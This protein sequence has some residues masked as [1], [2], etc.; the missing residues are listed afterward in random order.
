MTGGTRR[1][2]ASPVRGAAQR[3]A[4]AGRT[5]H[6]ILAAGICDAALTQFSV[7]QTTPAIDRRGQMGGLVVVALS[8]SGGPVL[9]QRRWQMLETAHF[10]SNS[11]RVD[12]MYL[13]SIMNERN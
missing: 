9:L 10:L 4:N 5:I 11:A 1:S 2:T 7:S 6:E 8:P 13:R 3:A 12:S